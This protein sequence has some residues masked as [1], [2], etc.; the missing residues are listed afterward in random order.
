MV[1]GVSQGAIN[2]YT[3]A[4]VKGDHTINAIFTTPGQPPST[5]AYSA[6]LNGSIVPFSSNVV[7]Y[8]GSLSFYIIPDINYY[9]QDVQVDGVSVGPWDTYTFTNVTADHT[10][11][12]T[13]TADTNQ[14]TSIITSSAGPNGSI[15]P[16]GQTLVPYFGIQTFFI[17]PDP[18]FGVQDIVVDGVSQG[19]WTDYSFTDVTTSH[20]IDVSFTSATYAIDV[21]FSAGGSVTSSLGDITAPVL[22]GEVPMYTFTPDPGYWVADVLVDGYSVGFQDMY[23]FDPIN[24]DHTLHVEFSNTD[25]GSYE[26]LAM[27]GLN[28]TITPDYITTLSPGGSQ[29]YTIIPDLGFQVTDVLV[30]GISVGPVNTYTFS[31]V[32]QNHYFE[33]YFE[34][35]STLTVDLNSGWNLITLP[36]QELDPVTNLPLNNTAES[37]GQLFGADV[38]TEWNS[39]SQQYSSHIVGLPVNNFQIPQGMGFFI[40]VNSAKSVSLTGANIPSTM[41]ALSVGWNLVGWTDRYTTSSAEIIGDFYAGSDVVSKFDS[42]TQQW[43]SHIVNLPINNF[44]INLGDAVFVHQQ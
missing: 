32:N 6:G 27:A 31:N 24:A 2:T 41:P 29:T 12:A 39:G 43:V 40:H 28:G 15:S 17:T 7:P 33:A 11:S 37:I 9:V 8:G 18:G 14:V 13:F 44:I 38:V 21:T 34:A 3:F 26:I 36:I 5:I 42:L 19:P 22:S 25:T 23:Q 10:I 20:T 35:V 30:D 1:D 4:N 16:L